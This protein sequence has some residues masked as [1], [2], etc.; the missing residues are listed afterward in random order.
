[1]SSLRASSSKLVWVAAL[2]VS[3]MALCE[4]QLSPNYYDKTC[5]QVLP[6]VKKATGTAIA[7]EHRMAASLLRLHF[8]DCFVQGCD[9]SILLNDAA[10]IVSEKN[11]RQN[12]RSAR[13]YEV[14][15]GIKSAVE[16]VCPGVVSCADILAI[17]ARDSSVYVGGPSWKVKLGR[18][19]STTASKDLAEQNLPIAFDD[20][21]TLTSV[22][23]RQGLSLKDMVVLS[24]SHTIGLAQCAT[25]RGRIYNETNIDAG[26]A[27]MRQRRCPPTAGNGDT[28]LA[29][30]DLVTP[31]SF[32]NN[33]YK[34][35][36][37]KKGLLHSD[38]LLFNGGST[39]ATVVAYSKDQA[40][41]FAD[42][43]AA[44]VKMGDISPLT[45]S[46]GEVRKVCSVVN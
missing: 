20:L 8:H 14:I 7:R 33:Y 45:G 35:L 3:L 2:V 28:N 40:A 31:G 44:M 43:A 42:F 21:D 11:A 1:M 23:A 24:G 15:D 46:A 13:G 26:F 5:P 27:R 39:D 22:F 37:R 29:P 38:Q 9:A 12:F 16:K 6:T 32:D 4:A 36:L 17:V 34:N 41:F 25:F 30:L 10:G 19:D 18:R